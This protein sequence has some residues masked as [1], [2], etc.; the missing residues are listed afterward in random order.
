MTDAIFPPTKTNFDDTA[1]VAKVERF[2]GKRIWMPRLI[3]D[4]LGAGQSI[5]K[6][7]TFVDCYFE[8]PAVVLAAGGVQFDGCNMGASGGDI[9]NLLL[10]PVGPE[11]VVGAI[12]FQD[13]LF[14]RCQ[15]FSVGF[16][17]SPA[18][19]DQFI[20]VLGKSKGQPQ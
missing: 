13:C 10:R 8:G 9:R 19:L 12:A 7:K 14:Q 6:G 15:F 4:A 2:E 11:K 17:G 5:I 20:E 16:T 18:F 3:F 1:S